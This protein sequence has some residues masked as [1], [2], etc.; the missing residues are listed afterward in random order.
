V[1]EGAVIH[2]VGKQAL[3]AGEAVLLQDPRVLFVDPDRLVEILER[4]ARRM[5]EAVLR[6]G[7]PLGESGMR[8]MTV[9]AGGGD[10]MAGVLPAFI[11]LAHD[12]AVD[13]GA[14]I[15]AEV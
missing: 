6:L 4:E 11:L 3:M 2:E 13:A 5:P 7:D 8:E 15:A 14:R 9:H 10:M 12:V 1:R